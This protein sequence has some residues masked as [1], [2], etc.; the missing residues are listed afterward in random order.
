MLK[1]SLTILIFFCSVAIS[2][3]SDCKYTIKPEYIES[4]CDF[5]EGFYFQELKVFSFRDNLPD[6]VEVVRNI[7]LSLIKDDL[8]PRKKI[9]FYNQN[10]NYEWYDIN[11]GILLRTLPI[12]MKYGKWYKIRGLVFRGNPDRAAFLRY[13]EDGQFKVDGYSESKF[14]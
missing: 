1:Y 10:S 7:D 3:D 11:R 2:C 5:V 12:K 4:T 6:S 13:T 8:R 9:F 14:Y